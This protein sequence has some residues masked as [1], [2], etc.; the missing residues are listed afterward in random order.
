V[1]DTTTISLSEPHSRDASEDRSVLG[2]VIAWSAAQPERIGEVASF[3]DGA[4]LRPLGRGRASGGRVNVVFRRERPGEACDGPPLEGP[5]ISREQLGVGARAGVLLV[6]QRG[7]CPVLVR[8]EPIERTAVAPGETILL[9]GQLLLVCVR[10]PLAMPGG[11]F[12]RERRGPFGG[13]DSLGLV[14]ESPAS[15]RLREQL[16]FAA[17]TREHVLLV[18]ASGTGKELAARGIHALSS[19]AQRPFVARNAATFPSELIDAELFGNRKGYPNPGSPERAGII[20]EA[21]GGTLFLDEIGELPEPLQPH[22]LRVLDRGG[23]YQ[24]L[25]DDRPRTADLRLVAATNR[26]TSA[27]RRDLL[28]RFTLRVEL[29]PLAERREDVPLIVRHLL[30]RAAADSSAAVNRYR[31][32][33]GRFRID[34]ALIEHLMGGDTPANVRDLDEL[35]WRA[36]ASSGG[37]RLRLT[38]AVTESAAP[39]DRAGAP[40]REAKPPSAEEIRACVEQHRGNLAA[41]AR[42][43]RLPSRYALYRLLKNHGIEL[44]SLRS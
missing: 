42:A 37:D 33:R 40:S 9:K 32:E 30:E 43:L 18:G 22:L 19:R 34:A 27:L 23:E 12:P 5:G 11:D 38:P 29:P 39:P 10:R 36:I 41:A 16:T 28:A 4:P 3:P 24:R 8:G 7:R 2:L 6:E 1:S 14:G 26:D 21:D 25:G 44:K 35:V 31:D 20:G 15:W 17:A 13:P